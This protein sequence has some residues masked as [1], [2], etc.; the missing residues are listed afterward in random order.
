MQAM[1]D[2]TPPAP[3]GHL[4]NSTTESEYCERYCPAALRAAHGLDWYE[5]AAAVCG[6]GDVWLCLETYNGA[7]MELVRLEHDDPRVERVLEILT[8]EIKE[9]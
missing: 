9:A 3:I 5:L 1:S 8:A 2:Y 6:H 4:V 7:A